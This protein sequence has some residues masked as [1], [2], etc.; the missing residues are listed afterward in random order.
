[1]EPLETKVHSLPGFVAGAS[2]GMLEMMPIRAISDL[3]FKEARDW[4]D[5]EY[6]DAPYYREGKLVG[7]GVVGMAYLGLITGVGLIGYMTYQLV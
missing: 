4:Y 3:N 5:K 6:S 1:M 7:K 2:T